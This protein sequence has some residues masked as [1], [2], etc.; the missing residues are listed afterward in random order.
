MD[1][2]LM[3]LP[4]TTWLECQTLAF[5]ILK[6]LRG[7]LHRRSMLKNLCALCA[8]DSSITS[9]ND[10][11]A[12][13][14]AAGRRDFQPRTSVLICLNSPNYVRHTQFRSSSSFK[15]TLR[16]ECPFWKLT[17][18]AAAGFPYIPCG[19]PPLRKEN[20]AAACVKQMLP[21][22]KNTWRIS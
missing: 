2:A 21:L 17:T 8:T 22:Y 14:C 11:I 10:T 16:L 3:R 12:H 18:R 13:L 20:A 7:G 19:V 1:L 5:P 9:M 4:Q 6:L 15:R